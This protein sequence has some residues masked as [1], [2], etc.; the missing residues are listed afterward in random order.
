MLSL[1]RTPIVY[2]VKQL[3]ISDSLSIGYSVIQDLTSYQGN[4]NDG[5]AEVLLNL[6]GMLIEVCP[7]SFFPPLHLTAVTI[8]SASHG[9]GGLP[10]ILGSTE[11][12]GDHKHTEGGEAGAGLLMVYCL[13]VLVAMYL[14]LPSSILMHATNYY[15]TTF[16]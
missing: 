8:V 9:P 12:M 10:C 4:G 13:L 5:E 7:N 14:D 3:S 6:L 2:R 15:L 11:P 16:N 1:I